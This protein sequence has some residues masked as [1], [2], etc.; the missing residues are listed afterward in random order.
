MNADI[1][2]ILQFMYLIFQI[3]LLLLF[4]KGLIDT[5]VLPMSYLCLTKTVF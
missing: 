3:L 2:T 4:M 5:I 1:P